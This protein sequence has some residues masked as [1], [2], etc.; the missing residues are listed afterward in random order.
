M[1]LLEAPSMNSLQLL[2][3]IR[4]SPRNYRSIVLLVTTV[5]D[6]TADN[7]FLTVTGTAC[8]MNVAS[9]YS[10]TESLPVTWNETGR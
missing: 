6:V 9:M 10:L 3:R 7:S 4:S 2:K 8:S 1:I 5:F